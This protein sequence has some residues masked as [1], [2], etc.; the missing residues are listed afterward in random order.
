MVFKPLNFFA[1]IVSFIIILTSCTTSGPGLFGKKT[2]HELYS[3]RLTD[4]GLNNSALGRLWFTAAEQS[5]SQPLSVTIPYKES[6]YFAADRPQ[7]VGLKFQARRGEKITIGLIKKPLTGFQIYIDLWTI[8]NDNKT[9]FLASSDTTNYALTHEVKKSGTYLIR[10]QPELLQSG[11][12]S[13][14]ISTGPSLA[15]PIKAPGKNHIQSFWGDPRDKGV[16]KHEGIDLFAAFRTPVVASANGR[17]TRVNESELGGKVVW[18]RPEGSDY[19]LYYAHLDTQLVTDGQRVN[20]GDTLGLMG[21]TGNAKYTAPHLH[22]GIYASEGAIDP[23]P[24]VNPIIKSPANIIADIDNVGKL[25]RS[26]NASTKLY[27]NNYETNEALTLQNYT[28]VRVDAATGDLYK[29]SLPEG[30][31]GYIKSSAIAQ[32]NAIQRITLDKNE[33][34]FES[35]DSLAPRKK[36]LPAAV[37]LPVVAAYNNF[38]YV[39][40]K[41]IEGWIKK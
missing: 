4:A 14:S 8:E 36:I 31:K 40:D 35:P 6:G 16:R 30:G 21:N 15:Y 20:V 26:S 5:L 34:V 22:F 33:A 23:L 11:E 2:P 1:A 7:A 38:Y 37:Q 13:L 32:L 9:K 19:V 3:K 27:A 18:M 10:L 25:V 17:V 24:F 39:R 28:P 29:V 12:Y 41:N